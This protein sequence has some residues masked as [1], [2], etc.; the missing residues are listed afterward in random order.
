MGIDLARSN[1][2]ETMCDEEVET[3][4]LEWLW[5][6][7]TCMFFMVRCWTLAFTVTNLAK[8]HVFRFA[9][10]GPSCGPKWFTRDCVWRSSWNHRIYKSVVD[11]WL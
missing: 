2:P 5:S 3:C 11:T 10:Y 9:R 6:A 1:L 8:P 4:L 7:F